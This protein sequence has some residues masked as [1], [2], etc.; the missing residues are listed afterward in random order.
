MNPL[1]L[2]PTRTTRLRS[3]FNSALVTRFNLLKKELW[4][5]LVHEDAFG[6]KQAKPLVLF[7]QE[8]WRYL[9][10]DRKLE[11]LKKWLKFKTGQLFL[12]QEY[13]DSAD[14]W[15]GNYI[16]QAYHKGLKRSWDDWK[17]P[18]GPI[19]FSK[20]AGQAYQQGQV[21]EFLRQ[22]FGGPTPIERVKALATR[23]FNDVE[24]LTSDMETKLTRTLVDGMVNGLSPRKIG[25]ELNKLVEGYKKRGTAI[26]RTEII[27]GFNEGALDG[28][29]N[30]GV[31]Q[32]GVMVEWTT[33]GMGV[34]KKGNPSPCSKCAPL[35]GLVLTV[36]EA[37]GLLPRHPNCMCSY[38]PA[39][40]GE[41]TDKQVRDASR[42]RAAIQA[43]AKNDKS[44]IGA[45]KKFTTKK[46]A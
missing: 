32:I 30:L 26:A 34:T 15:L 22:S 6:L 4:N 40:V 24:G 27:R 33:S 35:A 43:S 25:V 10:D 12:K 19:S 20:E 39:N 3:S 46:V 9:R 45:K 38:V 11:E 21:A 23:T 14:T 13:Q 37:R 36:E 42:I 17:K 1:K 16:K 7:N 5:L 28:L 31:T 41:K 8:E 18:T 2:D 44:W 29:E